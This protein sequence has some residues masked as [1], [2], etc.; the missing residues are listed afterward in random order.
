VAEGVR[1]AKSA[2]ELARRLGVEMPITETIYRVLYEGVP[3][4][5]AV[6]TLMMRETKPE[7]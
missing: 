7:L 5:D 1:N 3:P 6:T 2:R 4:R